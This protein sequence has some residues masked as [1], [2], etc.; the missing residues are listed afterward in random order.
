MKT[1]NCKLKIGRRIRTW[2][3]MLV[4][5]AGFWCASAAR[6]Q[7]I[8]DPVLA[9]VKVTQTGG[10]NYIVESVITVALIGGVLFIICKSSRRS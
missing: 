6:A 5:A 3:A 8:V 2:F 9:Q 7:A 1:V 4:A 10:K